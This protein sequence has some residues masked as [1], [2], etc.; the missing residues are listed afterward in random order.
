MKKKK[1]KKKC[2]KNLPATA[3]TSTV[4][5]TATSGVRNSDVSVTNTLTVISGTSESVDCTGQDE[6]DEAI[7]PDT[8]CMCFGRYEDDVLEGVGAEWI[9][10]RC[11]RWVHEDCVEETVMDSDRQQRFCTF[12]VDKY[13]V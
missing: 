13:T 7:D 6:D 11:D 3:A 4:T 12:C 1:K 5:R 8:C 2:A 9:Y 10:C